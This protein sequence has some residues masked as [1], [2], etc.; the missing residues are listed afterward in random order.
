MTQSTG[1][2]YH[3]PRRGRRKA[4]GT[5]LW[6]WPEVHGGEGFRCYNVQSEHYRQE[7]SV[8]CLRHTK[9]VAQTEIRKFC[10]G[11]RASRV[12]HRI[13]THSPHTGRDK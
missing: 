2:S 5:C 12:T 3:P 13:S 7:I 1:T 11:D 6:H 8:G 9:K 10:W 4:C